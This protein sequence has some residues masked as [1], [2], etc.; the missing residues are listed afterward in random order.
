ML[1]LAFPNISENSNIAVQTYC[2]ENESVAF[3][4]WKGCSYITSKENWNH[5]VLCIQEE[6]FLLF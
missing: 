4:T 6:Y 2:L 1:N 5:A 3:H